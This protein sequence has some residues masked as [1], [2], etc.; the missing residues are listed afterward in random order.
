MDDI[1]DRLVR[2]E[3]LLATLI[4]RQ[5][6][7]DWY[8]TEQFAAAV[9]K[10]EFTVREWCRLGRI[11]AEKYRTQSGGAN[12]WVIRFCLVS[13]VGRFEALSYVRSNGLELL[14]SARSQGCGVTNWPTSSGN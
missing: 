2:I 1:L 13:R 12:L 11:E 7:R 8:N 9:G 6:V 10:A 3:A 4:D 5:V 14:V